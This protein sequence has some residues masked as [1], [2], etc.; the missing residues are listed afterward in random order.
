MRHP[1]PGSLREPTSPSRG[2]VN[3]QPDRRRSTRLSRGRGLLAVLCLA[4]VAGC[5]R[6]AG[7]GAPA[8]PAVAVAPAAEQEPKPR[9]PNVLLILVDDLGYADLGCYGS[10]DIRT[11]NIDKLAKDGVRL[12]DSYAAA[13]ICSPTRAALITGR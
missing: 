4:L 3:R 8:E 7:P 13:A 9:K 5:A 12:T 1:P 2:E 6:P 11:P 10:K